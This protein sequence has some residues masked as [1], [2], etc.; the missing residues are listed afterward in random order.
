MRSLLPSLRREMCVLLVSSI[1]LCALLPAAVVHAKITAPSTDPD[2]VRRSE[3]SDY[4]LRVG[5]QLGM[6]DVKLAPLTFALKMKYKQ[7]MDLENFRITGKIVNIDAN[8]V[9]ALNGDNI[10]YISCDESAYPGNLK[11]DDTLSSA[12]SKPHAPA[13]IILYSTKL[14]HCS[15]NDEEADPPLP[16]YHNVFTTLSTKPARQILSQLE[17]SNASDPSQSTIVPDMRAIS[18]KEEDVGGQK[19]NGSSILSNS[20][21]DT[22]PPA[23]DSKPTTSIAMIILYSITGIITALFLSVIVTGAIRAH[24]HPE[25]YGPRNAVGRPRQSRA[26]GLARAMLET[27]PIVKFG[28]SSDAVTAPAKVDVE[29][30]SNDGD[31][32]HGAGR[33]GSTS[34]ANGV[35]APEA[36]HTARSGSTSAAPPTT[37]TVAGKAEDSRVQATGGVAAVSGQD[38]EPIG[39]ATND[40]R[41]TSPDQQ[42]EQG[43]LG[44]PICTDDFIKGQDVRLLPCQHKFHPECVDP[45]LINVSGT[46]P[47]CRV[48]LNPDIENPENPDSPTTTTTTDPVSPPL[49][50]THVHSHSRRPSQDHSHSRPRPSRPDLANSVRRHRGL[51]A[52]FLGPPNTTTTH[53]L[54]P[55]RD[56]TME[57]RLTTLRRLR[58]EH[59]ANMTATGAVGP[60]SAA[61]GV[62]DAEE[63]SRRNRLT[64]RLRERFRIRTRQHEGGVGSSPGPGPVAPEGGAE[65][66]DGAGAGAGAGAT[67]TEE[68]TTRP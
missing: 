11:A 40:P 16:A 55:N 48:N 62:A 18:A 59:Q 25:R 37:T 21:E 67:T 4:Y 42:Q 53:N 29:M 6:T 46:C 13:A 32:E 31:G 23:I 19:N 8:N 5:N 28:D 26:K 1:W 15:Y 34:A 9:S 33:K 51:S 17:S 49:R 65:R 60:S 63:Q 39:P 64:A 56:T 14:D 57:E 41:S 27:I 38:D 20:P 24:L 10:A 7:K 45:W 22:L 35:K 54:T 47:L 52:Y 58:S 2:D 36:A 3:A 61:A 44:C 66:N 12:I 68:S 30:A 50:D 43:S